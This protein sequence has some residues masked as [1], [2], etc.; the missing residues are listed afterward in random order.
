MYSDFGKQIKSHFIS[1]CLEIALYVAVMAMS[2][3][4]IWLF[5]VL[6]MVAFGEAA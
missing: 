5:L 2:V 1:D 4:G 3:L 6:L